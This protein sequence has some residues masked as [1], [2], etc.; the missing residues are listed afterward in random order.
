[1]TRKSAEMSRYSSDLLSR[2]VRA[3]VRRRVVVSLVAL[4]LLGSSAVRA[5]DYVI[6]PKDVL[7]V[8]VWGQDDL[9]KEYPVDADGSV[10]FP[11]IGRAKAAGLT[12]QQ[13]AASL[14]ELLEKDYLVN[15]QVIVS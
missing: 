12:T 7:R 11:L 5:E 3:V 10:P 13:F 8:I 4:C 15:P 14:K 6:G 2:P 9:S 1:M